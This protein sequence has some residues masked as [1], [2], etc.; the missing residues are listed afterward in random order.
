MNEELT[1]PSGR[2]SR[3]RP[4]SAGPG[5]SPKADQDRG[6]SVRPG[7]IAAV[8]VAAALIVFVVQNGSE[9]PVSWLFIE[10][11]GPLWAVIVVAAVAGAVLSEIIS[12]VIGR[13][14]R[15]RKR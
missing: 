8:L 12:W 15:R 14:R 3:G 1:P 2:F 13:S 4:A 7:V 6:R 11:N 10:V 5:S 9:V